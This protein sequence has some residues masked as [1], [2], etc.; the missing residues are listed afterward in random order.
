MR[1]KSSARERILEAAEAVF[2]E[3]GYHDTVV[4]EIVLRTALSKGGVYFHFPS[5]ERLF[6]AVIDH[7]A[8]RLV[9]RLEEQLRQQ[10]SARARLEAALTTVLESLG[11]RRRLA[12][13]LLVQGYS[14]G[15]AFEKKR[16]EVFSRFASLIK[17]NL[18][19]AVAE[20]S[21]PPIDTTTVA[22][23]WLG[24]INETV[25]RW[26]YSEDTP[27]VKEAVPVLT[28]VLLRGSGFRGV[29]APSDVGPLEKVSVPGN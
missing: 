4:D 10:T 7:L 1:G 14:M 26:L 6:F 27:P 19:L 25:V 16:V 9:K 17:E 2:A 21:I 8:D 5:K 15:N 22:H 20:G 13:L 24:A 28:A 12:K 29:L 11:E 23:I 18:D 3:K